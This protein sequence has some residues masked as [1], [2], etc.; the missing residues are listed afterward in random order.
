MVFTSHTLLIL[1]PFLEFQA[2][3]AADALKFLHI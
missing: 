3:I 1:L 2:R